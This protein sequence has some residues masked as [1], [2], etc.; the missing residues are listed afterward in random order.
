MARAHGDGSDPTRR[1]EAI[2][3]KFGR[4]YADDAG[5]AVRDRPASLFQ[6]LCFALLSSAR[7]RANIAASAARA[8]FDQGWTTPD[9]LARS[10]WEQRAKVLNQAG[11][12][13]YD[14]RTAT[15]LADSTELLIDRWH[16]DLRRLRDEANRDPDAERRLLQEFKG[17][18]PVGADIFAREVQ[19]VWPEL[20]PAADKRSLE[21][22]RRLGLGDDAESLAQLVDRNDFPR[23]VDGLVRIAL[24][25]A[26]DQVS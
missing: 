19:G 3:D 5:I 6:L 20:H 13:R 18:G 25:D 9:K 1:A 23:L 10:R 22:A 14:E 17:V 4:T 21:A 11:Y 16:G 12:A 15:M 8:L 26:Y 24:E 7:I 2:L